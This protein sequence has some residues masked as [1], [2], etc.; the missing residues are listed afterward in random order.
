MI[1][2]LEEKP[3]MRTNINLFDNRRTTDYRDSSAKWNGE[4]ISALSV[5]VRR[6]GD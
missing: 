6:T 1:P 5:N 4:L 2:W 3:P